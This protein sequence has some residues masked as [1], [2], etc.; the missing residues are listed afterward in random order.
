MKKTLFIMFFLTLILAKDNRDE[1]IKELKQSLMA[2]CCWSG[3][4]YDHGHGQLEAEIED[5]VNQGKTKD[6][7]LKYYVGIYGE[8]ILAVPVAS[9]FNLFAWIIPIIIA[10]IGVV[11]LILFLRAPKEATAATLAETKNIPHSDLIEKELEDLD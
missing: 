6:E 10:G 2:P 9:G 5:F 8:R 11:V 3:T 7:I 1:L 4:V